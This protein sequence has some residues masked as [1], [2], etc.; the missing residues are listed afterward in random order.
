[1]KTVLIACDHATGRELVRVA[2]EH[3]GYAVHEASGA[4]EAISSAHRTRPDLIILDWHLK[5]HE[6]QNTIGEMRRDP[7]LAEV[8]AMALISSALQA[9]H[10]RAIAA[11]FSGCLSKPIHLSSLRKEV[12]RLLR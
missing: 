5:G 12:E 3:S 8:P 11:G 2:L 7:Q 9:D 4:S 1:M 6:A 10:D